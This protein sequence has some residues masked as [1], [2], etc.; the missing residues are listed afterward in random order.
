MINPKAQFL[1]EPLFPNNNEV[2]AKFYFE[3]NHRIKKN[4]LL[5]TKINKRS[6]LTLIVALVDQ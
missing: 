5:V 1:G 4:S 6:N 3:F 2:F